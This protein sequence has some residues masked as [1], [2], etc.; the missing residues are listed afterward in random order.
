MEKMINLSAE[1]RMKMG[2]N[3]RTLVEQKF[4]IGLVI[5]EY[6]RCLMNLSQPAGAR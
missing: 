1:E 4:N 3:G 5:K 2:K 6:E